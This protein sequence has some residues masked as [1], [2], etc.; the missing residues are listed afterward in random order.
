MSFIVKEEGQQ[1]RTNVQLSTWLV[2]YLISGQKLQ[3]LVAAHAAALISR[4]YLPTNQ[5]DFSTWVKRL[6]EFT[7][8]SS[9]VFESL[10]A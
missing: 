9:A 1:A 4:H 2:A 10:V 6:L 7:P 5:V 3:I 8:V